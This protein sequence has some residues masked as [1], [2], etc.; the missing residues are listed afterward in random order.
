MVLASCQKADIADIQGPDKDGG[1]D[2]QAKEVVFTAEISA[3]DTKTVLY[4]GTK[5]LWTDGDQIAVCGSEAAMTATLAGPSASAT[6]S[7]TA[8]P[9]DKGRYY[10][11]YPYS[12]LN[13]D[14]PWA[15]SVVSLR[16]PVNQQ[17]AA[18]TFAEE[19]NITAAATDGQSMKLQFH[20]LL[21]Y[22]KFD[23]TE[24]SGGITGVTV[25][26]LGGEKLAGAFSVDCTAPAAVAAESGSHSS[27]N[28]FSDEALEAGSYYVAMLPGVYSKG[29]KF[30]FFGYDGRVATKTVE[31]PL[32]LNAGTVNS[33][34]TVP[35]LSWGD[36][37][38]RFECESGTLS[39][40]QTEVHDIAFGT[41]VNLCNGSISMKVR[42]PE[43]GAYRFEANYLTWGAGQKKVNKA[44]IDGYMPAKEVDFVGNDTFGLI[45]LGDVVLPSG[46]VEIILSSS[47]GWTIFDYVKLTKIG[48]AGF[49]AESG[50]VTSE[51]V[52]AD[53]DGAFG[54][55]VVNIK[56]SG[57][58]STPI[59]V[60]A[61]GRYELLVRYWSNNK[62]EIVEVPGIFN[63]SVCE[64]MGDG[65]QTKSF[66]I[67]DL[68]AGAT[69]DFVGTKQWGWS[70]WDKIMLVETDKA[71]I[72]AECEDGILGGD[73]SID[74]PNASDAYGTAV[75]VNNEGNITVTANIV[76]AGKYQV[77]IRYFNWSGQDK[78]ENVEIPGY[79]DVTPVEFAGFNNYALQD[80]ALL[81][82][83]VGEVTVRISKNWGWSYFDR[84]IFT[85]C[86]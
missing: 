65:W 37:V 47:W 63:K 29:L 71:E 15:G 49:E 77:R 56:G 45:D 36:D 4:D 17:A 9:D 83:P 27:V 70:Y 18:G 58:F 22:M 34:G 44:A 7:G 72:I 16:L 79:M 23:I 66:G 2:V 24:T 67:F 55:K 28:L 32:T 46:D 53:Q 19:L 33:I 80:I 40:T 41:A 54:G 85:E 20:N 31:K 64:F 8:V 48:Y 57:S 62:K 50:T 38:L 14:V 5:V 82:L 11:V 26:A 1:D 78:T 84:V 81:E 43:E 25:T 68:T 39:G 59:T 74:T 21:G 10:A 73:A 42:I 61:D 86:E 51:A 75:R 76:K 30:E 69:Y 35:A 6:F 52:V 12:A 60:P 13:G 3:A